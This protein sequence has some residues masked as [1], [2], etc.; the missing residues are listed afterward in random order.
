MQ[1][2]FFPFA[3]AALLLL[4]GCPKPQKPQPPEFTVP[5][6]PPVQKSVPVVREWVGLTYGMVNADIL[7]QVSGY[8]VSQDYVDGS[9]VKKGQLLF[10]IDPRPFKAALDQAS[11]QLEQAQALLIRDEA[12]AKRAVDLLAKNVISREQYD[13]Q[14]Q[15]FE[16][17]KA[18]VSAAQAAVEQAR[19]NLE[20][21]SITAPVDGL[22]G[23]AKAQVGNLIG[24]SSGTLTTVTMVDPIKV[25]FFVSEN[26]YIS[27]IKPYFGDPAHLLKVSQ[28]GGLGLQ[29]MLSDQTIYPQPGRLLA[30]NNQ[31]S[32][33]TGSL[34]AEAEFANPGNL[35]R[36]GQFARVRGVTSW[37]KDALLVPQRAINDLQGKSQIAVVG[38]DGKVDLR[39]VETGPTY[40]SMQVVTDGLK[41]GENVVVEGMQKLRQGMTVKTTPWKMPPG[42]AED[43]TLPAPVEPEDT[44][45]QR[46]PPE[47]ALEGAPAPAEPVVPPTPAPTPSPAASPAPGA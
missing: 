41:P 45:F 21:T 4:T 39:I 15:S 16:S 32:Q 36:T 33:N 43:P 24:P 19:L 3:A 23:I 12:N 44:D 30:I 1:S 37:V 26:E 9:L 40:A 10:Q 20:F 31:V 6:A 11:G 38:P 47:A 25:R 28:R 29:I 5:V 27:Y 17:S 13:D 2:R 7:A 42:F 35:L 8:L 34:Q 18:A 14:I 46:L 22:A